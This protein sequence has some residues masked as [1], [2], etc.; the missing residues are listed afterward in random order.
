MKG[1]KPHFRY[2]VIDEKLRRKKC[3]W[4][5]LADACQR[6][7]DLP[8]PP[9][10][11]TIL[12]DIMFLR[13]RHHAPIPKGVDAYF[14]TDKDFSIFNAP[15]DSEEISQLQEALHI[16][17][18]LGRLTQDQG[19]DDIILRLEQHSG[20]GKN[21]DSPPLVTFERLDSAQ[22]FDWFRQIYRAI[23]SETALK[24]TYQSFHGT[25]ET[26]VFHPYHLREY[27]HRWFAFGWNAEKGCIDSRPLD[28]I[29]D[30]RVSAAKYRSNEDMNFEEFFQER[31]G[32]SKKDGEKTETVRLLLSHRRAPY[33]QTKPIHTSQRTH[34]SNE[35][36]VIFEFNLVINQELEAKILEF[37]CDVEVIAP[38]H[39]RENVS[40][41]LRK[42][43]KHYL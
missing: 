17:K 11:S 6:A 27:N 10:K 43:I 7:L 5:E 20:V 40:E 3:T 24:M 35:N 33:V 22:G 9:S 12:H 15:L 37:G 32:V 30:I 39:L 31:I 36:G 38:Q 26:F 29:Q 13:E 8:E 16:L 41:N 1:N 28:R 19:L 14:Y 23:F 4:D 18:R 25:S 21:D 34:S 2:K 42:S